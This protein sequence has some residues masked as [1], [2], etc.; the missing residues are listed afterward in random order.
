MKDK[1]MP[2][3]GLG[4]ALS[5]LATPGNAADFHLWGGVGA[6][7]ANVS[8]LS[9]RE[10]AGG[11]IAQIGGAASL[12]GQRLVLDSGLLWN[13]SA[14][15]G[16]TASDQNFKMN[17]RAG[18]WDLSLR[19]RLGSRW[20]LGPVVGFQFGTDNTQSPR[21]GDPS[22]TEWMG[23]LRAVYQFPFKYPVRIYQQI[24]TELSLGARNFWTGI[25]GVQIGIPFR[26]SGR[27]NGEVRM[28]HSPPSE[29]RVVLDPQIVF[30][31]TGSNQIR[32]EIARIL[33]NTTNDLGTNEDYSFSKLRVIGH[34][35]QRGSRE[36]NL[37]LSANRARAVASAMGLDRKKEIQSRLQVEGRAY[38]ELINPD[39][40]PIAWAQN[41]RVEIVFEEPTNPAA[42]RE[43]LKPLTS[44]RPGLEV[45]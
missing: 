16:V 45:K 5:L 40:D 38:D 43:K 23:A 13:R 41:R 27:A 9:F 7:Y 35:D 22:S 21:E 17:T 1:I 6:G 39:N 24:G 2:R 37:R 32:P 25:V 15:S 44:L 20:Q 28:A 19:Y 26:A 8:G 30:F 18:L 11:S 31:K 3:F 12:T 36:L 33:E 14:F 29:L 4:I 10:D 34:T 42:L